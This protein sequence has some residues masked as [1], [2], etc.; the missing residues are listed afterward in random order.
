MA[1]DNKQNPLAEAFAN[2]L[3]RH[4][5]EPSLAVYVAPKGYPSDLR[6][7]SEAELEQ[8]LRSVLERHGALVR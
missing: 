8:A 1:N 6:E 5:K 7:C 3:R 2:A 4:P